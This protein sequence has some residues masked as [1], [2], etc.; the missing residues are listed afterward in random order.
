MGKNDR[1]LAE[2]L[3]SM[4]KPQ[5]IAAEVQE[6]INSGKPMPELFRRTDKELP[7]AVA[8]E[9][10]IE[11]ID[12]FPNHPYQVRD[13]EEMFEL[14]ESIKR[15]GQLEPATVRPKGTRFEL[16]SGHRRKRALELNGITVIKAIIKN[17]DDEEATIAM[18]NSNLHRQHILPSE[19]AKAYQMRYDALKR[20]GERRDLTSGQVDQKLTA[21]DI[22]ASDTGESAKQIDRYMRLN[23][24]VPELLDMVDE[25][26]LKFIPA[27]E[28]SYFPEET[29]R[30]LL[31]VMES[32]EI[33][34]SMKAVNA[35]RETY[36]KQGSLSREDIFEKLRKKETFKRTVNTANIL[37]YI[38][39]DVPFGAE[40]DFIVS[41]IRAY[42]ESRNMQ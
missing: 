5:Q 7:R 22:M 3:A 10:P 36:R 4:K 23:S 17:I 33:K 24:L 30:D 31:D 2:A 39:E 28:I 21:R 20:Q 26:K 40:E 32:E 6:Q 9:I 16:I 34:P 13:D 41:A 35:L 29:Q 37:K 19:K 12:D 14:M 18:V 8:E 27:V 1:R 11:L 15:D 38:P 25:S 42:I